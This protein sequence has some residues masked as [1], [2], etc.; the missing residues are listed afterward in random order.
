MLVCV[1]GKHE[2]DDV[3]LIFHWGILPT[4]KVETISLIGFVDS[5]VCGCSHTEQRNGRE[6]L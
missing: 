5:Q 2:R 1:G 3:H 6:Y 4:V